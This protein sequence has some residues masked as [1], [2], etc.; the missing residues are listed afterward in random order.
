MR[1]GAGVPKTASPDEWIAAL[2]ERGYR[3]TVW[4]LGGD[5]SDAD[6]D[7]YVEAADKAD[8]VIAE[9]GAWC[10]NPLSADDA[11][12]RAAIER[13]QLRLAQAEHVG[14]RCCVNV[15][16]SRGENWAGPHPDDLTDET[17]D[18]LVETVREIVDAVNPTRTCYAI[19]TMPWVY[20]DSPDSYLR[21]IN[22]VDRKGFAA[23][24]DP[25]NMI[26]TPLRYFRN[27]E[28]IRECFDKLAPHIRSCHAKDTRMSDELT[29]H[30][31]ECPVGRG[32]LDYR[33]YLQCLSAL[34]PDTPLI[35]EHCPDEDLRAGAEH[36]RSLAD[37]LGVAL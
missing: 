32:T 24:L 14:A 21:L 6:A 8:I 13:C 18:L 12:R 5:A 36:L 15:A 22:A 35:L 25:V 27:G 3:A 29:V 10:H 4:P 26:N 2:R 34:E 28:F 23:H 9:V 37:E 7:A 17:F 11:V 19:E 20:P 33:T 1:I 30:I 31:S 16:G